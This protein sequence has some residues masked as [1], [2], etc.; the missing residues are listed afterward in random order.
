VK[1]PAVLTKRYAMTGCIRGGDVLYCHAE[2]R[3][4]PC[5]RRVASEVRE[6]PVYEG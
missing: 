6:S 2:V 4:S 5:T 3:H 1:S